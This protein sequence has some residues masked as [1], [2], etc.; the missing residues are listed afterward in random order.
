MLFNLSLIFLYGVVGEQH[1]SGQKVKDRVGHWVPEDNLLRLLS[2]KDVLLL[3]YTTVMLLLY[4]DWSES[5][6]CI[7]MHLFIYVV[8]SI[9]TT[10]SH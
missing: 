3:P 1:D 7:L 5:I 2:L 9:V 6:F 10:H 8:I 4:S